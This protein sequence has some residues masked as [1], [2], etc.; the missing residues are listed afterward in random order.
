MGREE[1]YEAGG[2][3]RVRGEV[4]ADDAAV[5]LREVGPRSACVEVGEDEVVAVRPGRARVGAEVEVAHGR[6]GV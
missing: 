5:E 3:G 4:G 6:I 2:H 1:S